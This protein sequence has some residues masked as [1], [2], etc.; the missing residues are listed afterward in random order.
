L[1]SVSLPGGLPPAANTGALFC[2]ET[3]EAVP[4]Q[5][6]E[7]SSGTT[8][9]SS[10]EAGELLL[11]SDLP[12]GSTRSY[13][14]DSA[15]VPTLVTPHINIANE[16]ES[17]VIDTGPLQIRI[18]ASQAIAGDAPGPLLAVSRGGRWSGLSSLKVAGERV[19]SIHTEQLEA[20][21]LRSTHRITYTFAGGGR[22]VATV[23]CSAGTDFV[24]LQENM[25]DVP[26]GVHGEFD[27]A[28]TGCE[29][30]HR[31]APNHPYRFPAVPAGDYAKYPWE[32]IAP[33]FMDTQFGVS[34]GL[35][36]SGR[37][38]F[39]LRIF[40]PWQ[41]MAAASFAN[42]WGD[43][44]QDAAAIF[45]DH[46]E[47]WEDHEYAI[48]HSSSRIA[49]EFA[50][51]DGTLHFVW[52]IACG[53][54]STCIAFYDH[55]KDMEAMRRI[56]QAY[57][58]IEFGGSRF[59]SGLFPASYALEL[60]NWHGTLGLDK[61]KDWVLS[62]PETAKQPKRLFTQAAWDTAE[63]FYQAVSRSDF[64]TQLAIS[65]VRQNHGFGPTSSRPLLESWIPCYQIYR[66]N[67]TQ[68]QRAHIEGILLLLAYVHA[69]EDY[70]PMQR[71][72]SGHPNFLSDVKS[73][74][75][76][77]AYLFPEHPAA[78]TWADEWEAYLHLNTRYHTRP[79]VHAW[80]A[81]GGRW[82][83]NLGTYVWA[84]L[85][86]A[87]RASFLLKLRDGYERLCTAQLVSLSDWLVNAL[88]APFAGETPAM[89]Q[90]IA[91]ESEL[92]E[93]ARR[94]YWGVVNPA[95]GPRRIHP[96]LG[97]H[98]ER[99]KPP[100]LMW[101]M[102]T[103]LRN[104]SPL[105]AEYLM[106]A[107][108]PSDQDMET[109]ADAVDPYHVMLEQPA[110]HGTNPHLQTS[111]FTGYGITLRAAV[112]RPEELSIHLLQIDD[113]PNYRWGGASEG[114]C[115]MI[116][117]YANGKGYSHNGVE[118]AGDRTD[119][120]T[121]FGSNFGVW[122]DKA[123]RSIGQNV[124]SR[125]LYDLGYAQFAEIVPR[126]GPEAY[127]WPEYVGRSVM[128]AGDDYFV[129]HD[130]VFNA[131]VAH[132]F[133]WFVRKGDEFPFM[134]LLGADKRTE[135]GLL[136]TI[137]TEATSGRWA[138]G[139]GD[140]IAIITHKPGIHA[141]TT[142]FG[143]RIARPDGGTD[144]VFSSQAPIEFRKGD[145]SFRGYAG[146]VREYPHAWE[147]ALFHGG[148][149]AAG[150]VS[151]TTSDTELGLSAKVPKSGSQRP[152]DG[153]FHAPSSS[154]VE[155]S[156]PTTSARPALYV[157]GARV[158]STW[159]GDRMV[160]ELAAGTHRWELTS[161]LPVPL[162][163]SIERTEYM[164]GGAIVH[165]TPV[166]SASSYHAE[167]SLDEAVSWKTVST[168][169]IPVITI[170]GLAGGRKYHVRLVA[171][172]EEHTSQPG[173]EYPLYITN[174]PPPPPDGLHVE[175]SQGSA[176]LAWG[177]VLGAAGYRL[178]R[179]RHDEANFSVVF[180]GSA[181]AWTDTTPGIVPPAHSPRS[182]ARG[183]AD[184]APVCE[185]FVTAMNH[186]GESRPSR[187]ANTDPYSWRNW[188]PTGAEPFRRTVEPRDGQLPNDGAGRY[189]PE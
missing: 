141:E 76:G 11:F 162:S 79:A 55:A 113:G 180:Q 175:L 41:D 130:R 2:V 140:S 60:Q 182:A 105:T 158:T 59:R 147:F 48:W 148:H 123:F 124:L 160:V 39:A 30:L 164:D 145:I 7:L 29:F 109:P 14:F 19:V 127:S 43:A 35:T 32:A 72:L 22:Y 26:D 122:K 50:F 52:K 3:G 133:S 77:M 106:W 161:A 80:N 37:M 120:D 146:I 89:M 101:Y 40:D 70:M 108:R 96:P 174:A 66:S 58:G 98:S 116:Y 179:K 156:F 178:H 63:A 46:A 144:L 137:E 104:Y 4:F 6:S 187:A 18:P 114:S 91:E 155:I 16:R 186:N 83:E 126:Q 23:Q 128:L 61:V 136:T 92:N 152:L 131:Q 15:A 100:R 173:P 188:N 95:D 33:A 142:F 62:Y 129:V 97:A 74:P 45:I 176:A 143:A 149:I 183:P 170:T 168:A 20:G 184:T 51:R 75:C 135:G 163:P 49:V 64:V 68:T 189:Y 181:T 5:V 53:T 67:L 42:F 86:P 165:G 153:W 31:Q 78:D 27:F 12:A 24:R 9:H 17:L 87:T 171:R 38:P 138:D 36:A 21:P 159:N 157:D 121:D 117:F 103:A 94:H 71:M 28:W 90:R 107:A 139:T 85:R 166:A 34:P 151:F 44:S 8:D 84:F 99:R 1:L 102:G 169:S 134:T 93:G 47:M 65:G 73:T 115:G 88:S 119:Q 82:T 25:E 167:I 10:E 56:E 154:S 57:D 172:N 81:R 185:Y 118:D 125:P 54:R 13:R 112:D 111:K 150:G 132:R 69:G 177:E 110:N